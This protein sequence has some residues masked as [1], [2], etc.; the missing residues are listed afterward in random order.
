MR[1]GGKE[2]DFQGGAYS[3]YE[4]NKYTTFFL[5]KYKF[6]KYILG[7]TNLYFPSKIHTN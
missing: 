7:K 2:V 1:R 6:T 4:N 3:T 5:Q